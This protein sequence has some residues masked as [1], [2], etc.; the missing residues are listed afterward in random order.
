MSALVSASVPH[1]M[2]QYGTGSVAASGIFS[3]PYP[4][5]GPGY[6]IRERSVIARARACDCCRKSSPL[7]YT[8][9][10]R[11]TP[12]P[13]RTGAVRGRSEVQPPALPTGPPGSVMR[14]GSSNCVSFFSG[15]TCC[16]FATARTVLP[17]LYASFASFAAAS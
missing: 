10:L 12:Y 15:S 7:T 8:A 6:P 16:S 2:K 5:W 3:A 13:R 17:D 9:P 11:G 14:Q 4:A 1:P